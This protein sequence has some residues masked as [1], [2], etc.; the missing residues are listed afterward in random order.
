MPRKYIIAYMLDGGTPA[1][2]EAVEKAICGISISGRKR[3][4][5]TWIISSQYRTSGSLR[6][7]LRAAMNED[8]KLGEKFVKN[9]LDL[10]VGMLDRESTNPAALIN[11]SVM[12]RC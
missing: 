5:T 11:A 1:E 4:N 3:L 8:R 6:S 10:I 12:D 9:R 7:K 2:Y